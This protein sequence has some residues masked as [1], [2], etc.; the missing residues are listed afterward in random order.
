MERREGNGNRRA[1]RRAIIA[2]LLPFLLAFLTFTSPSALAESGAP[3]F[4]R[5]AAIV[6]FAATYF[7]IAVGKL[8]GFYLDRAGAA[9][10]GA[11]L[12]VAAGVLSLDDALGAIDLRTLAL[13]LGM[14]IV[15][16]NL[17]LSGFFRLVTNH[18]AMRMR[19]PLALLAAVILSSGFFSA[20]LVNDAICLVMTPLVLDLAKRLGRDP[21]PYLLGVAA[22]SNI[23][24]VA[25][26]TGNPQNIMIGS[27]SNI[28]YDVF[29]ARLAP[30]AT[31][32]LLVSFVLIVLLHQREFL[33]RERL[34]SARAPAH[35]HR[36]LVFKSL[37][38]I[39]L[40]TIAFFMREPP[41]KVALLGGAFM[42][43]TR[44]VKSYKIYHEVDWPLLL[45]FSGLF[46]V[47]AG[48]EKAIDPASILASWGARR[49]DNPA[50]LSV[51]TAALSNLVSNVPA[52]M[53]LNPFVARLPDPQHAWLLV[54]MASTLSGNLTILGSVANLI[55]VEWASAGGVR[56]GFWQHLRLGAP[57]AL[58]T[59]LFGV[60]WI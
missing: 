58:L 22:A 48:F 18:L 42:L 5:H 34:H 52:V 41:A 35:A 28:P 50:L 26:I 53:M 44:A 3:Q 51:S 24:S 23:G 32:G 60:W 40:M 19:H 2:L 56:I 38:V 30:V 47:V 45:M 57:L 14:M 54:A 37:L 11:S 8:P 31:A 10:L 20:F 55:V 9:L 4:P 16:G 46:V 17:R 13:L 21:I 43:L 49:L 29:A 39:I 27:F 15:V 6:I 12:M 25:T 7:V 59:I 33:T 36:P 1:F